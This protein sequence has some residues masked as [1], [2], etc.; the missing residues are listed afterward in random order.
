MLRSNR[1]FGQLIKP[2]LEGRAALLYPSRWYRRCPETSV[3][4]S[5]YT[6]YKIPEEQTPPLRRG[7]SLTSRGRFYVRL[8]ATVRGM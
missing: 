2:I 8:K 4:N 5:H 3:A 1:R 6:L 7:G